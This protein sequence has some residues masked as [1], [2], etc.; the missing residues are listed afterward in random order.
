MLQDISWHSIYTQCILCLCQIGH[1]RRLCQMRAALSLISR[2]SG[3]TEKICELLL[4]LQFR[5]L[6]RN[7]YGRSRCQKDLAGGTRENGSI[8][9]L[10]RFSYGQY[11]GGHVRDQ[12]AGETGSRWH[13]ARP[14]NF[15][16]PNLDTGSLRIQFLGVPNPPHAAAPVLSN[17]VASSPRYQNV[18]VSAGRNIDAL[19][20]IFEVPHANGWVYGDLSI[21]V[22]FGD[23]PPQYRT[24]ALSFYASRGKVRFY[25]PGKET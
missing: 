17:L 15:T 7:S 13:S 2:T 20:Y 23:K 19:T 12:Q 4:P 5:Y 6:S 16:H 8:L 1:V 22:D 3:Q 21:P 9:D 11:R 24:V 10:P 25:L 18:N 14:A